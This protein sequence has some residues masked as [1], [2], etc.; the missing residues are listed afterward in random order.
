MQNLENQT[1]L[2]INGPDVDTLDFKRA[3]DIFGLKRRTEK[4]QSLS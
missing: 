4:F 3:F 1:N 2:S